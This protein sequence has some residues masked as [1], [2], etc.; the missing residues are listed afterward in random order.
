MH[1]L[2][3]EKVQSIIDMEYDRQSNELEMIA[4]ENYV[5]KEVMMAYS[6]VFTNKY[7]EGYIWKR[8]YWWQENVDKIEA[9]AQER[10]LNIFDLNPNNWHVNVQALS[11]GPA[12]LAVYLWLLKP[13]DTILW[14]DLSAGGHL[15][16]WHKLN[17]SWV[18]YNIV[19]YWVREDN[20]LIDYDEVEKKALE[21]KPS[22]ILAWFSAYPRNIDWSKFSEIADKVESKH[23][24]RPILMADIAHIA[25]LI[26]W[27]QISS[28]FEYFDIVTSTTHKTLR[29]PRWWVIYCKTEYQKEIDRGV[30]PGIQWWPH[31]HIIAAKAV[32]F[33]EILNS[34]FANYAKNVIE[35]AQILSSELI[36][37]WYNVITWWTDNHIVI[38]D[39][40]EK[41]NQDTWVAGKEVEEIL[42]SV[43]ISVNKNMIPF[44][45]R[46]PLDP[47]WLRLWTAAITTRWLGKEEMIKLANI[48]DEA[49]LNL[50]NTKK[51]QELKLKVSNICNKFPLKY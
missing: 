16:H 29:W 13:W 31:E 24:Y 27:K 8:Y 3:D 36:N 21:H 47:S 10:A 51:L 38:L 22:L 37:K 49:I 11:W 35:N 26:A 7:S 50:N 20:N 6:N 40:T 4:S 14:M 43:W 12:N 44:D 34:D 25:W 2:N 5:S 33:G 46:K 45:K 28:P 42:E 41:N 17:W 19:S 32:A 39:V 1:K 18:Y 48:I 9:L 23:W 15:S 30:F